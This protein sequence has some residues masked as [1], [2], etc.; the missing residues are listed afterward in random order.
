VIQFVVADGSYF[1]GTYRGTETCQYSDKEKTY[2][3]NTVSTFHHC[4]M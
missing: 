4:A 3:S 1:V 2:L